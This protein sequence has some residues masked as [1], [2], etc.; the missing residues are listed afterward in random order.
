MSS[1][2]IEVDGQAHPRIAGSTRL[3]GLADKKIFTTG[4]AARIC[5]ISQQTIIRCFD[6]GTLKGGFRVPGS[7]FRR[8]PREA[9]IAFMRDHGIPTTELESTGRKLLIVDDDVE[10]VESLTDTF[11]E[12]KRFDIRTANN[13]FQAGMLLRDFHPDL[14]L[15]DIMLPDI[16]GKEVLRLIRT[17]EGLAGIKVICMSGMIEPTKIDELKASGADDFI[18]KPFPADDL[19]ARVRQILEMGSP[20][21]N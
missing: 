1:V 17:D 3:G 6:N 18:G 12:D 9:L 8:I 5:N 20:S 7:K 14:V 2:A 15:L 19:V 21:G 13:G 4:E 11:A 16:N 10:L